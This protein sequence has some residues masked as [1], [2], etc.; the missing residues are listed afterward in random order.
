MLKSSVQTAEFK[1]YL[2]EVK[3]MAW[4]G[5]HPNIIQFYGA[6]IE[7]LEQSKGRTCICLN[8]FEKKSLF[9]GLSFCRDCTSC[10]GAESI[11]KLA[12]VLT[13]APKSES[14]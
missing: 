1:S 9:T 14:C 5:Q 11:W 3:L 10:D 4:I 2:K 12:Q 7:K 13:A 8:L 6:V